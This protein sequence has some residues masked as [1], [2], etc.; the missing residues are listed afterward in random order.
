[1]L[2]DL[3]AC[4]CREPGQVGNEAAITKLAV[5]KGVLLSFG[6][7]MTTNFQIRNAGPEDCPVVLELIQA[8]A[9]YEK[10]EHIC[11]ATV[12]QLHENLF[13]KNAIAKALL[14]YE[15]ADDG[16]ETPVAFALYFHNF[17]TFLCCKGLYL[18]DIFVKDEC[19]HK[20]Y[21]KKIMKHLARIAVEEG[22]GRFEWTV[23]DWNRLA[24]DFYENIGAKVLPDWRITRLTGTKLK[25]FARF[26]N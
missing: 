13:G 18:E 1:M 9:K 3:L 8:L 14:G 2:A 17:S 5:L 16:T 12:E 15:I 23:L 22:C 4:E 11:V 24:I 26:D 19:R 7:K 6:C 20:G 21:G 25:E 10:L